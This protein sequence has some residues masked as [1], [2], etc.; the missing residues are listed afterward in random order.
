MP[1]PILKFVLCFGL[2]FQSL[3]SAKPDASYDGP[4]DE[5]HVYLLIGQSNMAGRAKFS[6][7]ESEPIRDCYL[8]NAEDE[9]EPAKNPLNRHSTIRKSLKMQRM[10]P[11]YTFSQTM[12]KNR[13]GVSLG[14]VVNAK[15][16]T[17]IGQWKKGSE[18]YQDAIE[19]T[20]AAQKMGTL[21]GILWHQGEGNSGMP[22]TYL[23]HL[24]QLIEDL[25]EDLDA[26]NL[27][28]IAGQV[29]YDA[30]HKPNTK[31]INEEIA[32]LP[33]AV[34][35]TGCVMSDGLSTSDHTHFDN[36]G[37]KLLGQRYAEE[38]LKLEGKP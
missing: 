29:F 15:G 37:M 21:K 30:E 35:F 1:S 5:L 33:D 27:P 10:N 12:L 3:L 13:K 32:K 25:R 24:S 36:E 23:K 31:R 2:L 20:R 11:G 7:K 18:F 4:K 17:K 26:P 38:M 34:P 8:L 9:F 6:E 28:F 16:G 14:L 19:R 22:D